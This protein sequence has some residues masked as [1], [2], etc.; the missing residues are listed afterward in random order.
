MKGWEAAPKM[1]QT[2]DGVMDQPGDT[3]PDSQMFKQYTSGVFGSHGSPELN[4]VLAHDMS[5]DPTT[6]DMEMIGSSQ[7][8]ASNA[9]TSPTMIHDDPETQFQAPETSPLKFETPAV[10]GRKRNSQGQTL[11]SAMRTN[12][13]PG[14][15]LSASAFFGFGDGANGDNMSLTQAFNATQARTSPIVGGTTEDSVFQR[16]SP[17]FTN[18]RHRNSSPPAAMSSPI[19]EGARTHPAAAESVVRSSSE[20]RADYETL[21]QSQ[22]RRKRELQHEDTF[23]SVITQDSWEE[24]TAAQQRFN[25]RKAKEKLDQEAALSLAG[26]SASTPSVRRVKKRGLLSA[27]TTLP[28]PV[29]RRPR[30]TAAFDGP[31]EIDDENDSPDELSQPVHVSQ[32]DEEDSPDELSQD[33]PL[34]AR[35]SSRAPAVKEA[36]ATHAVQV[37]NTSSHP[38]A[39][40]SGQTARSISQPDTPSSQLQREFQFRIPAPQPAHRGLAKLKGSKESEVIMNSQPEEDLETPRPPKSLRFPSSP[41]ANE[42]SINQTVM[43]SQTG[44]LTPLVS[45]SMPPM[46]PRSSSQGRVE[47][48][49]EPEPARMEAGVPSSPPLVEQDEQ[50]DITYDEHAY[51]EHSEDERQTED[52]PHEPGDMEMEDEEDLPVTQAELKKQEKLD[53]DVH[54]GKVDD[55]TEVEKP[56][57]LHVKVRSDDEVPET[58]EQDLPEL[59][60][61]GEELIRSS[62]PEDEMEEDTAT[63]MAPPRVQRQS[64]VPET[65]MLD[66]TQPSFFPEGETQVQGEHDVGD[67][68]VA[69]EYEGPTETDSTAAFHTGKEQQT[70]SAPTTEP[71]GT[72]NEGSTSRPSSGPIVRP[73][74]EIAKQPNTQQSANL[75]VIELP[76]LSFVEEAEAEDDFAAAMGTSTPAR[77]S[78]KRKVTYSAKKAFR[79]PIKDTD[80]ASDDAPSSPVNRA[81]DEGNWTP[82]LEPTQ[83]NEARGAVAAAR[84]LNAARAQPVTLKSKYKPKP[85]AKSTQPLTPRNGALRAVN[86]ELFH[87]SPGS[88]TPSRRGTAHSKPLPAVEAAGDD[89]DMRDANAGDSEADELAGPSPTKARVILRNASDEGEAPVGDLQ[90]S[91]RVFA[92]WPQGHFWPATCLRRFDANRYQVQYDFDGTIHEV[93]SAS[94][95][96]LDLQL[97]D[98]VKIEIKG[99]KKHSWVIVGFKNK[100]G[101]D[102]LSDEYSST[103]QRG[104][105]TL[106]VEEKERDSLPAAKK[107]QLPSRKRV[108]VQVSA[109]YLTNTIWN[110]FRNAKFECA[111]SGTPTTI[112]SRNNTP[113]AQGGLP[114]PLT[115]FKRSTV[116]QSL[117]RDSTNRAG[118]VT[119][120]TRSSTAPFANMV[121]A[122]SLTSKTKADDQSHLV[123][124]LSRTITAHGGKVLQHGFHEMFDVESNRAPP[125]SE[126]TAKELSDGVV[127]LPEYQD[128]TFVALIS[129]SHSRRAKQFQ[130]LALNIPVVHTRWLTDSI[131]AARAIPFAKY[132]L[133]AG[134]STFFDPEG[135]IRSRTMETYDLADEK[136][137]FVNMLQ[138]RQLF[139]RDQKILLLTGATKKELEKKQPYMFLIHA[140]GPSGVGRCRDLMTAKDMVEDEG[141]DWVC[142]DGGAEGVASA[143]EVLF[144][145][146]K[147]KST[148]AKKRTAAAGKK[149]KRESEPVNASEVLIKSGMVGERKVHV[150]CDEFVIQSLILGALIEDE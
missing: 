38:R 131:A 64:T 75:D 25:R 120:S 114:T 108:D 133:P 126:D 15:V 53:S 35:A 27:K 109:I 111:A 105:A 26:V 121:F 28:S 128:V 99:M 6:D 18:D 132:L 137:S 143:A 86:K 41:S 124:D 16:P 119:S 147:P 72:A 103:D 37:P 17:N 5:G 96:G 70:A 12:T 21:K 42:Y 74:L 3:Q 94:I 58:M 11:S 34:G 139:F 51:E 57:P 91:N 19:K 84:A 98:Q 150:I 76:S 81:K 79:S 97:G 39:T 122:I 13:T 149:R 48:P 32:Q 66:E 82:P 4:L 123:S 112:A 7:S 1:F 65:D 49:D 8:Q 50:D 43:Q 136:V 118:S 24:P 100:V 9:I 144:A 47:T 69:H 125:S 20:P 146:G 10:A 93:A 23:T 29:K 92:A 90:L 117:L 31:N 73:L 68:S 113:G 59:H 77:P 67:D 40:L 71:S 22:D 56:G 87:R 142:V 88:T 2:F 110:K 45:S 83:E 33:V 130:A 62:H 46:P 138:Q 52:A 140:L 60:D 115:H 80:P 30:A 116:G 89:V 44:Q 36:V 63:P 104:Y 145:E 135:V 101:M 78:K 106:V 55:E 129:N 61:E 14:T 85:K 95:R 127:L 148:A 107:G 141:W 54:I 102:E 134:I